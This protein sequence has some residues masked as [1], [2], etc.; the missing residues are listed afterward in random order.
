MT[1]HRQR[2]SRADRAIDRSGGPSAVGRRLH[3]QPI[4]KAMSSRLAWLVL[5]SFAALVLCVYAPSLGGNFVWDDDGHVTAPALRDLAGL[6]AIWSSPA[7]T[8]RYYP[9]LHTAFWLEHRLWGNAP[10]GYRLANLA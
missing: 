7:R 6:G 3:G 2:R 4:A 9:L 8:Q 10:L 5:P 1:A